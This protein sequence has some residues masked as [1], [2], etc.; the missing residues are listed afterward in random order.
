MLTM[1]NQAMS[2]DGTTT[3]YAN[4]FIKVYET[5]TSTI[6]QDF[7]TK[8]ELTNIN[9]AN[10]SS[11]QANTDA[12]DI[13]NTKQLQNFNNINAINTDLTDN[14]Q[15][16]LTLSSNFY[17]KTEV[18]TTFT[19]YYTSTQIDTNLSTN[20]QTNTVLATNFCNKS[21]I[22]A[23]NWIDATALTPYA[24]TSTLTAN[25]YT[26]AQTQSLYY[27]KTY[28]D[29]NIGGGG[30]TTTEVDNLLDLRV[31]KSDFTNRFS[32]NP[33]IDCSAPTVIHSGLTLKTL[34]L[35]LNP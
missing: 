15:T 16:N 19:N 31:P 23:N 3:I 14:Y 8:T 17:T 22:D 33:I 5:G 1:L 26:I 30:Y 20:Y 21:E 10:A 13:L 6:V 2:L 32:A 27:D 24:L 34:Q 18:D 7:A 4:D 11:I 12:I 28:I 9:T 25:Y 29:A 35:M